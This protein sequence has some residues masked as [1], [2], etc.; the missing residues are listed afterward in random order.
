MTFGEAV[1]K[2][3]G[4]EID[5][6]NSLAR[7]CGNEQLYCK[8]LR[9]F[10]DDSTYS[11]FCAA[12]AQKDTEQMLHCAHTLKGLSGNLGLNKVYEHS[13]Y[14]VQKLRKEEIDIDPQPLSEA[15]NE[16]IE[17]IKQLD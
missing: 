11:D 12:Y 9:K 17:I 7:M 15:Y 16:V 8:F 14:I 6:K 1:E 10:I 3:D 2:Y 4:K 5:F 13:A